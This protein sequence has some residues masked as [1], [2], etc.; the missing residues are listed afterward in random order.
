MM[1][2]ERGGRRA[3]TMALSERHRHRLRGVLE[4]LLRADDTLASVA[5][6][7]A[8]AGATEADASLDA[9]SALLKEL[10]AVIEPL[11]SGERPRS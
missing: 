2:C 10:I 4:T 5:D 9:A 11:A 6:E 3:R 1:A 8:H 7:L